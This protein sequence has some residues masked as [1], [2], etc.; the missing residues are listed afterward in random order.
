MF[1]RRHQWVKDSINVVAY[2]VV[3][4]LWSHLVIFFLYLLLFWW[5]QSSASV[6]VDLKCWITCWLSGWFQPQTWVLWKQAN[7]C[8]ENVNLRRGRASH[9]ETS[10]FHC[11]HTN[12]LSKCLSASR[13]VKRRANRAASKHINLQINLQNNNKMTSFITVYHHV[14]L[15]IQLD[16][17]W[18]AQS[19]WN[20]ITEHVCAETSSSLNSDTLFSF[21]FFLFTHPPRILNLREAK[22]EVWFWR[23]NSTHSRAK[24]GSGGSPHSKRTEGTSVRTFSRTR[25]DSAAAYKT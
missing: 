8:W 23:T 14:S 1:P 13:R 11:L 15:H 3:E 19:V 16:V 20:R 5:Y 9:V 21:L 10:F 12:M 2:H 22:V 6:A 17:F 25:A 24:S 18:T 7:N 4:N